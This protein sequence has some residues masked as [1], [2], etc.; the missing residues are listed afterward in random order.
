[1]NAARQAWLAARS[2]ERKAENHAAHHPT[3]ENPVEAGKLWHANMNLFRE[4]LHETQFKNPSFS[5]NFIFVK[6]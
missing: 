4:I 3:F 6:S 5:Y 2:A 1:M